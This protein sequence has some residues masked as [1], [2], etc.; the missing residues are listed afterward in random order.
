[1]KRLSRKISLQFFVFVLAVLVV[2]IV[3]LSVIFVKAAT[4]EYT[5]YLESKKQSVYRWFIDLRR[6]FKSYVDRYSMDNYIDNAVDLLVEKGEGVVI[7]RNRPGLLQDSLNDMASAGNGF[8]MFNN[9][10]IYYSTMVSDDI[11]YIIGITFD[12]AEIESLSSFLGQDAIAFLLM[13]EHFV[14]PKEF[15]DSGL[16]VRTVLDEENWSK[17]IPFTVSEV[18]PAFSFLNSGSLFLVDKVSIGG[19]TIYVLQ[20]EG[21]LVFL[22]TEFYRF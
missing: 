13:E 12:N 18:R 10:L 3:L 4:D 6:D 15:S 1:M 11:Q 5:S 19:A 16:Y 2:L 14:I 22:K 20:S 21:L 7:L 8:K 9:Q 17:E